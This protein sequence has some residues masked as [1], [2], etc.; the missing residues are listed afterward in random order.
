MHAVTTLLFVGVFLV[1][2]SASIAGADSA[3]I[4]NDISVSAETGG[5]SGDR[6]ITND[7]NIEARI[8]QV[9]NGEEQ[10]PIIIEKHSE[11]GEPI[12]VNIETTSHDGDI[13]SRVRATVNEKSATADASSWTTSNPVKN[14]FARLGSYIAYYVNLIFS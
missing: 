6:V 11:N 9:I 4:V 1:L 14:F 13:Q 10:N 8:E 2:F 5:N 12:I 7:A 3:S